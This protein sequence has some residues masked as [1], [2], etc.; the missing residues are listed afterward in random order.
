MSEHN[1]EKDAPACD[2]EQE[3]REAYGFPITYCVTHGQDHRLCHA[4]GEARAWDE[5]RRFGQVHWASN[6]FP[7]V[8]HRP[9]VNP[10]RTRP[11]PPD[12]RQP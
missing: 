1:A 9:D 8:P 6:Y 11:L 10:Y 12:K 7:E 5:G 3:E 2:C 4:S